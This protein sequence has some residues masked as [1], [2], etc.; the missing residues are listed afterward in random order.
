M[1]INRT[2]NLNARYFN[3]IYKKKK[4]NIFFLTYYYY[5]QLVIPNILLLYLCVQNVLF[6]FKYIHWCGS[7]FFFFVLNIWFKTHY[8]IYGFYNFYL[9]FRHLIRFYERSYIFKKK[10]KKAYIFIHV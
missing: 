4:M 7:N 10:K 9:F 5:F 1:I 3:I 6:L 8:L 2:F